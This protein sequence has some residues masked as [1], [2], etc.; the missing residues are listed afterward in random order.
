MVG[1][2]GCTGD[3]GDGDAAEPA[4]TGPT[5]SITQPSAP[6]KV[7]L[8]EVHAGLKPKEEAQLTSAATRPIEEWFSAG[9][10]GDYPR[11]DFSAGFAE[12]TAD[13]ASLA[14]K[15]QDTTTNAALGSE[16]VA[17]VADEQRAD[18]YVFAD[19]GKAGGATA[20]VTLRLTEQRESGELV[21][22]AVTGAVYLTKTDAG[23]KIF[24]YDLI[25]KVLP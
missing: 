4:S 16:V 3:D 10:L 6:L 5:I 20:D 14:T 7:T 9:Y 1:L 15:D 17:V 22:V 12:W 24:G 19:S 8:K 21:K 13:A 2:V 11:D 25:R 23:W 18:L